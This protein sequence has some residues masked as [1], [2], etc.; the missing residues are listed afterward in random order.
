MKTATWGWYSTKLKASIFLMA[1]LLLAAS[2]TGCAT[3]GQTGA[4]T[5]ALAGAAVGGLF[6]PD[7]SARAV[8]A[9]I[10]AGIG[11]FGGAAVGEQMDRDEMYRREYYQR[12]GYRYD[13]YYGWYRDP[14]YVE[15][16]EYRED[17]VEYY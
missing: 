4:L 6:G 1:G 9:L 14:N 8:N 13:P 16:P 12:H 10:G 17:V 3:H 15:P 7:P 2:L 5:G 11:M